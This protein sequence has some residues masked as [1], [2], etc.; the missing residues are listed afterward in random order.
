MVHFSPRLYLPVIQILPW[1]QLV[2]QFELQE[3]ALLYELHSELLIM[4]KIRLSWE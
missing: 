2:V 3:D 4:R 1:Q